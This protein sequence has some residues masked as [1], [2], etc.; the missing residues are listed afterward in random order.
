MAGS[1]NLLQ[2]DLE[3]LYEAGKSIP[4]VSEITGMAR[5]TVRNRLIRAGVT[6]RSRA[7]G[8]RGARPKL[9]SGMRGKTRVFNDEHK[10]R[11]SD[12]RNAWAD[13]NAIGTRIT[14][15]GYIEFTR[16]P[17]KG[18]SEHVEI[19]ER[20]L[21]RHILPDE[22]VHHIDGDR[23]N[24]HTDNLALM[25]RAGHA[26]HHRMIERIAKCQAQ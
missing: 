19:M 20:R 24:N 23:A 13:E 8:V 9:G 5:S 12:G 2:V 21:G 26:R 4:E 14:Q 17:N 15:S 18:R 1:V 22:V 7:E 3:L 25:T 10:K 6:I 11:I 16:G